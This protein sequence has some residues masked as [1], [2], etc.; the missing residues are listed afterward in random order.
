MTDSI[1]QMSTPNN[2]YFSLIFS[3][4]KRKHTAMLSRYLVSGSVDDGRFLSV[5]PSTSDFTYDTRRHVGTRKCPCLA[6]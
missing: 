2:V 5:H 3:R 1:E 4:Y 6:T